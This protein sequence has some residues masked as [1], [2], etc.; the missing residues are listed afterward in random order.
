VSHLAQQTVFLLPP[1]Y[2][3]KQNQP[4]VKDFSTGPPA[5]SFMGLM[6]LSGVL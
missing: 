2:T 6:I 1:S 5:L 3:E 4:A